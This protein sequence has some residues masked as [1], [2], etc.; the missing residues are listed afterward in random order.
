MHDYV[1][2]LN[3]YLNAL[4][5]YAVEKRRVELL[6]INYL[7]RNPSGFPLVVVHWDLSDEEVVM[8]DAIEGKRVPFP[9]PAPATIEEGEAIAKAEAEAQILR[10]LVR[11][12]LARTN[13][14]LPF[15]PDFI[16]EKVNL[17]SG[18]GAIIR[19]AVLDPTDYELHELRDPRGL[20]LD[21]TVSSE[22]D[23]IAF[24]NHFMPKADADDDYDLD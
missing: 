13:V 19:W 7:R 10:D 1:I 2:W 4:R 6:I 8:W 14:N 24:G 12:E 21:G 16:P 18:L 11:E 20:S 22:L 23:H 5:E 3:R 9:L 17:P 15:G